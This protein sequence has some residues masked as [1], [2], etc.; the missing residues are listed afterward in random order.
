MI[1]EKEFIEVWNNNTSLDDV[2]KR[3]SIKSRSQIYRKVDSLGLYYKKNPKHPQNIKRNFSK[4]FIKLWNGKSSL[5]EIQNYFNISSHSQIYK[6]VNNLRLYRKK[7]LK[8]PYNK[9]LNKRIK[10]LYW[11]G[12]S[13]QSIANILKIGHDSVH[14]RL[15]KMNIDRRSCHQR[16]VLYNPNKQIQSPYSIYQIRKYIK[17]HINSKSI[18][19]I[20]K[21]LSVDR[22]TIDIRVKAM[23]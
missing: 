13:I 22:S 3:F 5:E 15:I 23:S 2:M 20:A 6:I 1:D 21:D 17:E 9:Y 10:R 12:Y 7:D 4:E 8:H 16:N 11:K 19:R 14:K 18:N